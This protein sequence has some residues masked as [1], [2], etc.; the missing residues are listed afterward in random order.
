VEIEN[1]IY[2]KTNQFKLNDHR[3]VQRAE[4]AR[5]HLAG[6]RLHRQSAGRAISRPDALEEIGEELR[7][8]PWPRITV[9]RLAITA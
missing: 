7:P 1:P 6:A 5:A 3:F 8:I 4:R 2:G 9:V